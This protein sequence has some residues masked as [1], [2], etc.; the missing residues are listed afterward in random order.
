[1]SVIVIVI[2]SMMLN[3]IVVFDIHNLILI[4]FILKFLIKFCNR[5]NFRTAYFYVNFQFEFIANALYI[6]KKFNP[7]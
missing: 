1:M 2:F 3:I 4:P 6:S 7:H 5:R